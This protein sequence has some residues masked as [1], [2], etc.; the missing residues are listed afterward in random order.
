SDAHVA[1]LERDIDAATAALAPLKNFV[2]PGG[3][4]SAAQ[5]HV[6]RAVCRRAERRVV[7]LGDAVRPELARYLNRLSDLLFTLARAENA[8]VGV[9]EPTWSSGPR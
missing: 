8:R 3:S 7:A 1:A 2:L 4:Q 6:A 5:L 9:A